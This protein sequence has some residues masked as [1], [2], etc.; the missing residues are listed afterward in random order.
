MIFNSPSLLA[1]S[2]MLGSIVSKRVAL[3][4]YKSPQNSHREKSWLMGK[5]QDGLAPIV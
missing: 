5:V 4:S 1:V 3:I 2:A